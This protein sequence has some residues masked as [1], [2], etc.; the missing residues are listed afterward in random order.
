[1]GSGEEGGRGRQGTLKVGMTRKGPCDPE[2]EEK[3]ENAP[4]LMYNTQRAGME[5]VISFCSV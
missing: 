5:V 3:E 2:E 4:S 1:M